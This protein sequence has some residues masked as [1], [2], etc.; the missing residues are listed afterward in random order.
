M[1]GYKTAEDN[2]AA[3]KKWME[4]PENKKKKN[5]YKVLRRLELTGEVHESSLKKYDIS[6][7]EANAIRKKFKL[8]AFR[9]DVYDIPSTKA[10]IASINHKKE[11]KRKLDEEHAIAV[12]VRNKTRQLEETH[13]QIE[14]SAALTQKDV[15][16]IN[17]KILTF[18]DVYNYFITKIGEGRGKL[19]KTTIVKYF[20]TNDENGNHTD[21]GN[22]GRFLEYNNCKIEDNIIPC[23]TIKNLTKSMTKLT[24]RDIKI[25]T[26]HGYVQSVSK[27]LIDYPK[28]V[29]DYDLQK[30]KDYIDKLYDKY[31]RLDEIERSRVKLLQKVDTFSSILKKVETTFDKD[32]QQVLLINLYGELTVRDDFGDLLIVNDKKSASNNNQNYLVVPTK[33]KIQLILNV[34]KT[35]GKYGQIIHTMSP[36]MEKKIRESLKAKPRKYL[37][38]KDAVYKS[39]NAK[40]KPTQTEKDL[41]GTDIHSLSSFIGNL[42]KKSGLKDPDVYDVKTENKG[43]V[44]LLRHAKVSEDLENDPSAK[45]RDDLARKMLHAPITQIDYVRQLKIHEM[46]E[47]EMEQI[48]KTDEKEKRKKKKEKK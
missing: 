19:K 12:D 4:N 8:P 29:E 1:P 22:F 32:S 15:P 48:E 36:Q 46:S 31:K 24:Q 26:I 5:K 35:D 47:N 9:G 38:V 11:L 25:G 34:Y 37:F 30:S 17:D 16:K 33:Q 7:D 21:V 27:V 40:S 13:K 20:G 45:N 41:Y 44:N 6:L 2:R 42:L 39:L 43:S 23:L 10:V 18:Y 3:Q 14:N 28:I